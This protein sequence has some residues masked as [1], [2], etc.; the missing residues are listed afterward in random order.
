[1]ANDDT[2]NRRTVLKGTAGMAIVGLAGCTNQGQSNGSGNQSGGNPSGNSNGG[3]TELTLGCS[4]QGSATMAAG[5]ALQRAL[6]EYSDSVRINTT[7]TPGAGPANFRIFDQGETD[8]GGYDNY[9]APD[10]YAGTGPFKDQPVEDIPQQGF[11]YISVQMFLLARNDTDIETVDDLEGK[12]V[13]LNPP[14]VGVRPPVDAVLKNAGLWEK[15]TKL[16]MSRSDVPGA[17][18]EGRVDALFVYGINR[19]GLP[20]W[21]KQ[22]DSRIGLKG[23]KGTEGYEKAIKDTKGIP[24]TTVKTSSFNFSNDLGVDSLPAW[25]QAYQLRFGGYISEDVIHE[26]TKVTVEHNDY[27]LESDS[28]FSEFNKAEDITEGYLSEQPVHRGTAS[29]LKENDAW[30]SSLT[31]GE[32]TSS[33]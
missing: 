14:G 21:V 4:T 5:Q 6:S 7:Q 26:I 12:N 24:F 13:Y 9:S 19:K 23:V 8:G 17:L 27:I 3:M 15:I 22:V 16:Q 10:A 2:P 33:N 32:K 31:V 11:Q 20:G 1:M 30:N 18:E 25:L 29:Y 28:N